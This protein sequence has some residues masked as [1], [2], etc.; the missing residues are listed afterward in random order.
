[1]IT[2]LKCENKTTLKC[3]IHFLQSV[4]WTENWIGPSTL[5]LFSSCDHLDNSADIHSHKTFFC[6]EPDSIMSPLFTMAVPLP[7]HLIVEAFMR[8]RAANNHHLTKLS[9]PD[10]FRKEFHVGFDPT[11]QGKISNVIL[12]DW[13][14]KERRTASMQ[15]KCCTSSTASWQQA[16]AFQIVL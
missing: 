5:A 13:M 16:W 7:L 11:L 15:T 8:K 4:V 3:F 10:P 1:M 6:K 12:Y 14:S 9:L 2:L